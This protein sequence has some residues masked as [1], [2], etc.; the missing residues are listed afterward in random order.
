MPEIYYEKYTQFMVNQSVN[1]FYNRFF[2]KIDAL[3]KDVL[4]PMETATKFLNN[5]ISEIMDL[6]I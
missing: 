4:L 2:F 6:L 3:P 5:L 1:E